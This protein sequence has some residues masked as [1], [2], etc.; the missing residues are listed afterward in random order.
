MVIFLVIIALFLIVMNI[1][2]VISEKASFK[3]LMQFN[4]ENSTAESLEILELRRD[5]GETVAE[6]QREILEL[7]ALIK[8]TNRDFL[9]KAPMEIIKVADLHSQE[10]NSGDETQYYKDASSK[11]DKVIDMLLKGIEEDKICTDLGIGRGEVLLIKQ[12]YLREKS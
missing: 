9:Q 6:L 5:L 3:E 2:A 12:L 7:R 11:N 8:D 4:S 10:N 1:K